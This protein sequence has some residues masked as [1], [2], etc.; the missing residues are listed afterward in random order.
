MI[1]E[2]DWA[3]KCASHVLLLTSDP[4]F[5]EQIKGIIVR[6]EG[7]VKTILSLSS[8]SVM[9]SFRVIRLYDIKNTL[10][11]PSEETSFGRGGFP[12]ISPRRCTMPVQPFSRFFPS[13]NL[14]T[15]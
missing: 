3:D 7:A 15:Q 8:K 13:H 9:M 11:F 1:Y 4:V 2:E 5:K 6:I 10:S 12:H 14:I